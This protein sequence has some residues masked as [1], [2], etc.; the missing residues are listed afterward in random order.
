MPSGNASLVNQSVLRWFGRHVQATILGQP[1]QL[2]GP[3]PSVFCASMAE[4]GAHQQRVQ[5]LRLLPLSAILGGWNLSKLSREQ[6]A[7]TG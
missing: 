2:K 4:A 7:G 3:S 1:T 5:H 6:G